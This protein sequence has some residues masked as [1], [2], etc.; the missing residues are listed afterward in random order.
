MKIR[1]L[2]LL[3]AAGSLLA[4]PA[5]ADGYQPLFNGKNFDDWTFLLR[6]GT[7][8]DAK[9]VFTIDPDGLLHVFRDIP[10]GTGATTHKNATHGVMATKRPYKYYSLKFEYKWGR[11]LVNNSADFQYD[12]GIIYHIT[13]LKIWP[14]ALQYQVRYNHLE[15]HNHT[16]DIVAGGIKMQWYSKDGK[17]YASPADGGTPQP[18]RRGQHYAQVDAPFHGLDD[19]WNECELIVMGDRYLL[20]KLN[21]KIVNM[22]T[23]LSASEGPIAIEAETGETYW[24]NLRIKEFPAPVPMEKFLPAPASPLEA[25]LIKNADAALSVAPLSVTQ[26]SRLAPSGDPHD[27]ASTAPYFW[28]D[29]AKPD[30]LPYIR[31]DGKINPESRTAASDIERCQ[32][33]NRTVETL[34]RAYATTRQEK[35]ATHAALLLRT[36]FIDPATRMRPHL[37]YAQGIPGVNTG[38]Q[39]GIIEGTTIVSALTQAPQL[40]G[41]QAW[42]PADH[43]ALMKWASE[44]L[45]W[46]L[47][48]PFGVKE[49]NADNNHGTHY[50]V[51]VM[52]MALLLGRTDLAKQ[53]AETAKKKRIAAQIEPDGRQPQELARA[54]SFSYS[55]MN[56]RGLTTLARLADQVGVDLWHYETPDGRSIRKALDFMVPY[57]QDPAKKWPYEQIKAFDRRGFAPMLE[58]ASAVYHE[59]AYGVLGTSLSGNK[60]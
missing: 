16:G 40:V 30:G 34:A 49:G 44:F 43:A 37:E 6:D 12:A 13:E 54:T 18:I 1:I 50:D 22:A 46:Y 26:K 59:P 11:K 57:L 24:R 4:E 9:K 21:G 47:T 15:N 19:K 2:A 36:W 28:P 42:T 33:M 38:R 32:L 17:T 10:A 48:S 35:Y 51:Q 53:V 39:I 7:P 23:D 41:S 58:Q 27:Y 25:D 52:N 14:T 8:E 20:H 31:H 56:L 29:P 55:Q 3:A 45:D 60:D 5:P